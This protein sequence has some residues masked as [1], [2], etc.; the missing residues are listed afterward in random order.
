MIMLATAGLMGLPGAED[1][2]D[3]IRAASQWWFGTDFDVEMEARRYIA[4]LINPWLREQQTPELLKSLGLPPDFNLQVSADLFLHGLSQETFGLANAA[5]ALGVPYVPKVDLS[6]SLS[7]GRL[8]PIDMTVFRPGLDWNARVAKTVERLAGAALGP[9]V[10]ML[11]GLFDPKLP[12]DDFKVWEKAMPRIMKSFLKAGRLSN[13]G[14]E[15]TRTGSPVLEFDPMDPMHNAELWGM[16]LGFQP[17]RLSRAWDKEIAKREVVQYWDTRKGMILD[18]VWH[19]KHVMNDKLGAADMQKAID[20][21]NKAVPWKEKKITKET[22]A[23]SMRA[24]LANRKK[25]LEGKPQSKGDVEAW[26]EVESMF[27]Q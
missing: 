25:T 23:R 20:R 4:T 14:M 22:V 11:N 18:Q 2:K 26:K 21:Y 7:M 6:G 17:T 24:R 5:E 1:L 8:A 27:V 3:V 19:A 16:A 10:G 9:S 12:G 15:R 13:E